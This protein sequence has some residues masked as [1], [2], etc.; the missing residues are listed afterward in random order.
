MQIAG[1]FFTKPWYHIKPLFW[2][3]RKH[4]T[5]E[6]ARSFGYDFVKK[7]KKLGVTKNI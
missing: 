2:M 7:V 3:T 5:L 6:S 4:K 1:M